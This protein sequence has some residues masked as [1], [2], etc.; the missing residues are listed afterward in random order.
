MIFRA[1]WFRLTT[2]TQ[3]G[4][5]QFLSTMLSP[6]SCHPDRSV[7]EQALSSACEQ[8]RRDCSAAI[9]GPQ[10]NSDGTAWAHDHNLRG[11]DGIWLLARADPPRNK[12][13]APREIA[14][15]Q[16]SS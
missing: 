15:Q 7:R 12:K 16:K 6:E 8:D 11:E 3:R 4:R 9:A 1:S 13:A 10:I 5:S 2:E 14:V